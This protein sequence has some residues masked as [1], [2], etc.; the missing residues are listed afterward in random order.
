MVEAGAVDIVLTVSL[1]P[2]V[3]FLTCAWPIRNLAHKLGRSPKFGFEN[4]FQFFNLPQSARYYLSLAN[5]EEI[6]HR[7]TP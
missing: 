4:P 3:A 1:T 5:G 2:P 7:S 6:P